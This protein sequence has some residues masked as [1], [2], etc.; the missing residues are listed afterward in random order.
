MR[1]AE[2]PLLTAQEIL[3]AINA[4]LVVPDGVKPGTIEDMNTISWILIAVAVIV[5]LAIVLIVVG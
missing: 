1:R 4:R 3:T 2:L 5:V